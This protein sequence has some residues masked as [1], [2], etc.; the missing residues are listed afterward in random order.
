MSNNDEE[1]KSHDFVKST[2]ASNYNNTNRS[3]NSIFKNIFI[4]FTSG[5]LG[6]S[7]VLGL[8]FYVPAVKD[9]FVSESS[10]F[11]F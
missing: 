1:K 8:C 3:K 6:A 7:L 4:S 5:I 11:Y 2:A 10:N 9:L